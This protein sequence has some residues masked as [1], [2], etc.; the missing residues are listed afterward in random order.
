MKLKI[1]LSVI[2]GGI[3]VIVVSLVSVI[4]VVKARD[5]QM[6]TSMKSLSRLG[7]GI[8]NDIRRRYETYLQCAMDVS[9]IL[10]DFEDIAIQDRRDNLITNMTSIVEIEETIIGLYA[11]WLPNVV[12]GNDSGHVG[13]ATASATGQFV[14][15]VSKETG[16]KVVTRFD[17]YEEALAGLT[18]AQVVLNP[19]YRTVRG[20]ETLTYSMRVPIKSKT[21]RLVGLLGAQVNLTATD[22]YIRNYFSNDT[23]GKYSDVATVEVVSNNGTIV[24]HLLEDRVGENIR[25][26]DADILR[27]RSEEVAAAIKGGK[28]FSMDA[29]APALD[30][31]LYVSLSPLII[32]TS[33]TPWSVLVGCDQKIVL[34]EI[35]VMVIFAVTVVI[36]SVIVSAGIVFL[37]A[38]SIAKPIAKVSADPQ[39]YFRRGRRPDQ[40]D[41]PS[42]Q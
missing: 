13:D 24:A 21:G 31:F 18:D 42:F 32:G 12:D 34:Q 33:T 19:V 36:I 7:E 26:A 30:A 2:V 15:W 8:T 9:T 39:G 4:L 1:R 35:N 29:Y 14:P 10:G 28:N 41:C 17:N 11:C 37:V 20:K 40:R 5:T 16:A 22:T 27:D 23:S 6:N 38:S 25:T 3:L